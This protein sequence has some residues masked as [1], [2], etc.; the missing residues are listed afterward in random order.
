M[1]T[2]SRSLLAAVT[3][4]VLLASS[5]SAYAVAS[6]PDTGR[7]QEHGHSKPT[8]YTWRVTPTGTSAQ[9]RG[10]APVSRKVAWVS[11][12][13]GTVLRTTDGGRT[14]R[15]VSPTGLDTETLQFRDIEAFDAR[16]A[17]I[18]SIGEGTD[19]RIL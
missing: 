5:T 4:A 1:K 14:W 2:P 15:D 3:L 12:T 7:G 10:L 8:A 6:V 9:F 18:L 16:H 13:D 11:G 17:V 19:S